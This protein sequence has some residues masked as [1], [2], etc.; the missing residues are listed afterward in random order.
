MNCLSVVFPQFTFDNLTRDL[1]NFPLFIDSPLWLN[2][3]DGLMEVRLLDVPDENL[4]SHVSSKETVRE[5]LEGKSGGNTTFVVGLETDEYG[6]PLKTFN[7][8]L[9]QQKDKL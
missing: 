5:S 6:S 4:E 2:S 8:W 9:L 7:I 3:W 1:V